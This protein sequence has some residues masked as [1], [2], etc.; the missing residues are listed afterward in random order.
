MAD[1]FFVR[2]LGATERTQLTTHAKSVFDMQPKYETYFS[3]YPGGQ[4]EFLQP[5][6]HNLHHFSL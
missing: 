4:C 2:V 1:T 3:I 6:R 5:T